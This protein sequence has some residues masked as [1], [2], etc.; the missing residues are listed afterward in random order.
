MVEVKRYGVEDLG[1][2]RVEMIV[3]S[4]VG[5]MPADAIVI[6][7]S[8]ARG[9]ATDESDVDILVLSPLRG[10]ELKRRSTQADLAMWDFDMP[11]DFLAYNKESFEGMVESGSPFAKDVVRDGVCIY[12]ELRKRP[13]SKPPSSPSQACS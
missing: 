1:E 2:R 4:V 13:D 5:N 3:D 11:T 7:G 6:F 9:E 8:Y 10:L 12:G